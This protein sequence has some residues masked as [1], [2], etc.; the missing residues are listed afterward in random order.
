MSDLKAALAVF[1][2]EEGKKESQNEADMQYP[3]LRESVGVLP[4]SLTQSLEIYIMNN[5]FIIRCPN[6]QCGIIFEKLP[7]TLSNEVV[8]DDKGK[9]LTKEAL[10]HY[11]EYRFRCQNCQTIFCSQCNCN[12]YHLGKTCKQV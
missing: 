3:S 11:L 9:P 5:E 8:K 7:P 12:P 2:A 6:P 1:G 10:D 4:I